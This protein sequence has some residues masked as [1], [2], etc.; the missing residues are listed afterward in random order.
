MDPERVISVTLSEAEWKALVARHPQPVQ[1]IR[2]QI[3]EEVRDR[4]GEA[5]GRRQVA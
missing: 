1:W 5:A 3:R 4:S 2:E